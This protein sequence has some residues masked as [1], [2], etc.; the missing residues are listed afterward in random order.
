MTSIR[1]ST[2]NPRYNDIKASIQER[3]L[4]VAAASPAGPRT[5]S[6]FACGN[7]RELAI[8]AS[9]WSETKDVALFRIP[10]LFPACPSAVKSTR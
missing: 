10:C 5:H 4:D 9:L 1:A 7:T 3:G 6:S 2:R 8:L